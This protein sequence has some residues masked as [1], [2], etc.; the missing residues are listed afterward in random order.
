M[1]YKVVK[2]LNHQQPPVITADQSVY[3]IAKQLKWLLPDEYKD[4]VLMMRYILRWFSCNRRLVRGEWLR[5]H[6]S[7]ST[8]DHC[9][10]H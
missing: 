10:V 6:F 9:C 8:H 7:K 2:E 3:V 4:V 5:D 1:I